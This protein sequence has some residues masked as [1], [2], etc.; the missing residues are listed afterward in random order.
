MP[1]L[2]GLKHFRKGWRICLTSPQHYHAPIEGIETCGSS[3]SCGSSG[4][5][6]Y[7]APIE[8]IETWTKGAI[9]APSGR[10]AFGTQH[11]H[12]PIEGIETRQFVNRQSGAEIP[13]LPCPD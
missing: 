10:K 7:H 12:A 8:G 5:Q 13:A 6:H 3:G 11:Y 2:R 9:N 4:T 1:R